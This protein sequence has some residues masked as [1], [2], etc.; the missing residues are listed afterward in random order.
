MEK[1][2]IGEVLLAMRLH[3]GMSRRELAG[4]V[5]V[6]EKTIR[7]WETDYSRPLSP[8]IVAEA[9]GF[10]EAV[11]W[12]MERGKAPLPEPAAVV[13]GRPNGT[14][15]PCLLAPWRPEAERM[16]AEGK[17]YAEVARLVGVSKQRVH[18]AF[19]KRGVA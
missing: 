5:E 10:T 19:G 8:S 7:N 12:R 6:S 13:R 4:K 3:A 9:L 15:S 2:T 18:Q 14:L 16:L 17:T 1:R 11:L